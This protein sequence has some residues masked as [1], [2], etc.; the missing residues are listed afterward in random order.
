MSNLGRREFVTGLA[1]VAVAGVAPA[2]PFTVT[3]EAMPIMAQRTGH[4]CGHLKPCYHDIAPNIAHYRLTSTWHYHAFGYGEAVIRHLPTGLTF[5][6]APPEITPRMAVEMLAL[7]DDPPIPIS[8]G[9][10]ARSIAIR[11]RPIRDHGAVFIS[12]ATMP[13]GTLAMRQPAPPLFAEGFSRYALWVYP[14]ERA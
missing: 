7:P 8:L 4:Y 1:A 5:L 2:L 9:Y 13:R 6:T 10:A 12:Y 3:A 14:H 11:S